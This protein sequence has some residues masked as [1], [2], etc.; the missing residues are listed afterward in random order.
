MGLPPY[1]DAVVLVAV[2]AIL[3]LLLGKRSWSTDWAEAS[4]ASSKRSNWNRSGHLSLRSNDGCPEQPPKVN[5]VSWPATGIRS[6]I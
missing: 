4:A 2:R 5:T 1:E 3:C 6:M